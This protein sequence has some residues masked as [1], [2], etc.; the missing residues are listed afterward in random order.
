MS[1]AAARVGR[2]WLAPEVVQT[3]SMD[4]GPAALK[5]LLEGH[6]VSASYGRLREA[7]QTSVDGTS[8]DTI[9]TV[10]RQLG[11][12]AE[13]VLI[14][15]DHVTVA[16]SSILPAMVVVR[17]ADTAA[18][19]V[20][21][22][23]R[24]GRWLQIMDPARGRRWVSEEQLRRELFR[25]ELSVNAID[26][27]RWAGSED[28]L[29]PLRLRLAALKIGEAAAGAIIAEAL[30]RSD[31]FGAGALDASTRLVEALV[32][33]G[34]VGRGAEAERL[35]IAMFRDTIGSPANIYALVPVIYWSVTPDVTNTDP[36]REML[37]VQGGV[38]MKVA[39]LRPEGDRV[40]RE[41]LAPELARALAEPPVSA[42]RI[43]GS[44]LREDGLVAPA[45]LAVALGISTFVLLLELLLFRG[46]LDVAQILALPSSRL[47][48]GFALLAF[49]A[50][51]LALELGI[52]RE[53]RRSG[54]ALE[55]RFRMALLRKL[56]RLNDRYFQSRPITDMAERGHAILSLRALPALGIQL[57]GAAFDLA[58]TF[59]AVLLLA[60]GSL[61]WLI[62]LAAAAI[63]IPLLTQPLLTEGDLRSRIHGAALYGFYLDALLGLAP[64]RA[65]RAQRAVER[66]HESLLVEWALAWRRLIRVAVVSG[67]VQGLLCIGLAIMLVWQHFRAAG[68]A[69]GADLLLVFWVLKL[70]ATA[71]RL[72]GLGLQ[73]PSQRNALLR[74]TEPLTAPEELP[75]SGSPAPATEA[76]AAIRFRNVN[77]LA[78]GHPVL[79]DVDLTIEPG[80]HVA[81]VGKSGA[82]KSTLV[83]LLLGWHRPA[84]GGVEVD[85]NKLEGEALPML[86]RQTAWLDPGVQLWNRSLLDN[87]LYASEEEALGEV[88]SVLDAARLR[89][90]TRNLPSGLQT[91]LGEGGGLLSGG[92]GQRVRLGRA[93]LMRDARL[94]LLDEPFRG[95]D[96]DQRRQLLAECRGW[97]AGKTLLCV[98]HDVEETLGFDRVLVVEDGRIVADG[99]PHRLSQQGGRYHQLLK[100]ERKLRASL[101]GGSDWRRLCLAEGRLAGEGVR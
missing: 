62:A 10:A 97:W 42:L 21:V 32:S 12:D 34:G 4:C 36:S 79:S 66:Q 98:T 30:S 38:V 72:A 16:G 39:G 85:G 55:I 48:G 86:R 17:H 56:P 81:I 75:S 22:W 24:Y 57:V 33:A 63:A 49:V 25:H 73:Y 43:I 18:H 95:L 14:P 82:G 69:S 78:G 19:F 93:L 100:A 76:A 40:A 58:L 3:S 71:A 15:I 61:G 91:M 51:L 29:G 26:W 31:W 65:H 13:Q 59:L 54:R 52:G 80:E 2:R 28:F 11:L 94:V 37:R 45:A 83:G 88:G 7:C 35:L 64:V 87:L 1:A 60:P 46:L 68:V 53:S 89:S 44:M 96:R 101:W 8:I 9:E 23:R 67:A 74:L 77:V 90:V 84:S 5:C 6:H 70:P 99:A 41:E 27:R 92:E 47:L 20:V 50:I